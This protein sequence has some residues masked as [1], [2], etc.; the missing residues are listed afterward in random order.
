MERLLSLLANLDTGAGHRGT[1]TQAKP[2]LFLRGSGLG[3]VSRV[4]VCCRSI[5]EFVS[6][7]SPIRIAHFGD[8]DLINSFLTA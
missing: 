3:K 7:Y 4:G 6:Y 8:D 2:D 1:D 5:W